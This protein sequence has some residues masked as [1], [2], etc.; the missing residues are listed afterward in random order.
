ML[1][2]WSVLGSMWKRGEED[3]GDL[4][5][6]G[7]EYVEMRPRGNIIP[8]GASRSSR[9]FDRSDTRICRSVLARCHY[10]ASDRCEIAVATEEFCRAMSSRKGSGVHSFKRMC[11]FLKG[12]LE[13]PPRFSFRGIL[14][15]AVIRA[16]VDSDWAG[17]WK[18]RTSTSGGVLYFGETAVRG[19][20][21][22]QAFIA[23]S[24][25][26]A[27]YYAALKGASAVLGFQSMLVDLGMRAFVTLFTDSSAVRGVI[28]RAGLSNLRHLAAIKAKRLL[29][30]NVAGKENVVDRSTKDFAAAGKWKRLGTL[31]MTSEDGRP[32]Q[33]PGIYALV[34]YG[35]C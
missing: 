8:D 22:T 7:I 24:S 10:V 11:C 17:C 16:F 23:L 1:F 12:Y 34:M 32:I 14:R 21:S 18:T 6:S 27:D 33:F 4:E 19:W 35:Y 29:I 31:G 25:G 28:R 2:I 13:G 3:D 20:T 15:R 5:E 30:R 9:Q 26:E